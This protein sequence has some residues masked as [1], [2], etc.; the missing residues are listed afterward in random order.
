M[1]R[2]KSPEEV[3]YYVQC[4]RPIKLCSEA[5]MQ[6]EEISQATGHSRSLI[7]QLRLSPND[8]KQKP[9]KDSSTLRAKRQ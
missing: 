1:I 9:P 2:S 3:E 8:N 7:R 4:L 6:V 5:G